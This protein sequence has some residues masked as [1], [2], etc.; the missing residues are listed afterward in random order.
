[1]NKLIK[2]EAEDKIAKGIEERFLGDSSIFLH[3]V[4]SVTGKSAMSYDGHASG[5]AYSIGDIL[6]NDI[7]CKDLVGTFAGRF[8]YLS[9]VRILKVIFSGCKKILL[10]GNGESLIAHINTVCVE[11]ARDPAFKGKRTYAVIGWDTWSMLLMRDDF[12]MSPYVPI[13]NNKCQPAKYWR[14]IIWIPYHEIPDTCKVL[15]Y[16]GDDVEC[17]VSDVKTEIKVTSQGSEEEQEEISIVNS[18]S[19]N[20]FI[21]DSYT[22]MAI[23]NK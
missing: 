20:V 7:Y 16:C 8:G 23:V 3:T 1:M 5:E 9:N 19:I 4:Q 14:G 13:G 6:N 17:H 15:V 10:S 22:I 21:K 18:F 2:K 11:A 12:A